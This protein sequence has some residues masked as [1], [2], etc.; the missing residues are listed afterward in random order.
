[1][2]PPRRGSLRSRYPAT[3]GAQPGTSVGPIS[4]SGPATTGND[5]RY[6]TRYLDPNGTS[7]V[8]V[9][10]NCRDVTQYLHGKGPNPVEVSSDHRYVTRYLDPNG[11]S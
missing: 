5:H 7:R 8:E 2:P 1:M 4:I 6:V 3:T 10:M 9:S 11:T